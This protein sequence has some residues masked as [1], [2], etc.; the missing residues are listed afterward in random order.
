MRRRG[1]LGAWRR[2]DVRLR[3]GEEYVDISKNV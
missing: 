2:I 1:V 3:E